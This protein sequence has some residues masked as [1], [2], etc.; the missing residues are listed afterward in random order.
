MTRRSSGTDGQFERYE[1]RRIEEA[2]K[3]IGA[4]H[5]PQERFMVYKMG[6]IQGVRRGWGEQPPN[7]KHSAWWEGFKDGIRDRGKALKAAMKK[8]GYKP[9]ILRGESDVDARD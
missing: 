5:S 9:N 4:K 6:Y 8:Y 2:A 7:Q 3:A 1:A